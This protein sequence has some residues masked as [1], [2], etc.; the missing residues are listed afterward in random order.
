MH[1]YM[2]LCIEDFPRF[3]FPNIN[4][5][6]PVLVVLDWLA[7]PIRVYLTCVQGLKELQDPRWIELLENAHKLLMEQ[8]AKLPDD[9]SRRAFLEN[10]PWHRE[11]VALRG[12]IQ[13]QA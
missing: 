6:M 2:V 1:A 11:I 7:D 3:W 10:I 13:S 8:A 12:E 9:E 4:I 5:E